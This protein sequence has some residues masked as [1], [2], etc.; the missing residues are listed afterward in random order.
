MTD[1]RQPSDTASSRHGEQTPLTQQERVYF[2]MFRAIELLGRKLERSEAVRED[3]S[4]RL[5][6]IESSAAR[7]EETGKLYLPAKI[8]PQGADASASG[9]AR[10][11]TLGAAFG[12]LALGVIALGMVL[13]QQ[14]PQ[15][16]LS[17]KQMAALNALADVPSYKFKA[18]GPTGWQPV[19]TVSLA[20]AALPTPLPIPP[21]AT[22]LN[23]KSPSATL[24]DGALNEDTTFQLAAALDDIQPDDGTMP[25]MAEFVELEEAP[26]FEAVESP[27]AVL[28][29]EAPSLPLPPADIDAPLLVGPESSVPVQT[30]VEAPID[31]KPQV[32]AVAEKPAA[33]P[34]TVSL[35][36][37]P[38]RDAHLPPL[39]SAMEDR[40]YEGV[41]EA[42]HDLATLYAGG[43]R[44]E[45]DYT[46]AAYWFQQAADHGIANAW[47]NLGVMSQQGVG[48]PKS[49]T[50]AF[51]YYKAA[52]H[53][54][55]PEAMYNLGL[56]YI[57]ARGTARDNLRGVSYFK[58]A[59]NAGLMQAAYN[60]GVLYEGGTVIPDADVKAALDWYRVAAAEGHLAS[61]KAIA[62]LERLQQQKGALS[63]AD[64]VAP[65]GAANLH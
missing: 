51:G 34:A 52:A 58:R 25:K 60:L 44:V 2:E 3:L 37:R 45:R 59:A 5:S 1:P 43:Q 46:R 20:D 65:A 42:Q 35:Q 31:I 26:A 63:Q 15:H 55:H 38:P 50:K 41:P 61:E 10:R 4:R 17:P 14:M 24:S 53:L 21:V 28:L 36:K 11:L 33:A 64:R 18:D 8:E 9:F 40:A 48:L 57:E 7:D 6:D 32:T 54:G 23:M 19:S 56:A 49:D 30:V 39:F 27:A 12:G 22:A 13:S 29:A 62:R 47:Y 16:P